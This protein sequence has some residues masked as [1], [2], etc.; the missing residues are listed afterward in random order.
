VRDG[1]LTDEGGVVRACTS[2]LM[3]RRGIEESL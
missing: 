2:E 1:A 3:K